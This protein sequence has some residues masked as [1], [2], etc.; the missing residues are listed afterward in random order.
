MSHQRPTKKASTARY[1]TAFA[2]LLLA[3]Y[4]CTLGCLAI[5]TSLRLSGFDHPAPIARVFG[6]VLVSAFR[7][8]AWPIALPAFRVTTLG[9]GHQALLLNSA[10]WS[11]II[12]SAFAAIRLLRRT[13]PAMSAEDP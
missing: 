12:V 8:L 3:H 7:C 6:D 13:R 1:L 11:A 2:L 9:F 5:G 4:V 10:A